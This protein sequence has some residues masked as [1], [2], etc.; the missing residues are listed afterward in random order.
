MQY[1]INYTKCSCSSILQMLYVELMNMSVSKLF[2]QLR[3]KA[4]LYMCIIYRLNY[5]NLKFNLICICIFVHYISV[6]CF[7]A[8]LY[9]HLLH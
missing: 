9:E 7:D 2:M 3:N 6:F 5:S 1:N 4:L 8:H